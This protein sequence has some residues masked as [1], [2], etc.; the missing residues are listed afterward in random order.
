MQFSFVIDEE[1]YE[2]SINKVSH[3]NVVSTEIEK[4]A[5]KAQLEQSNQKFGSLYLKSAHVMKNYDNSIH[6]NKIYLKNRL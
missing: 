5:M 6:A 2:I 1:N 4:D 3:L